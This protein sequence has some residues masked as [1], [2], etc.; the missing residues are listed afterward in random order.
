[1]ESTQES[2]VVYKDNKV[3]TRIPLQAPTMTVGRKAGMNVQLED[4]LISRWHATLFADGGRWF[5]VDKKSGNGTFLNGQRLVADQPVLLQNG[6]VADVGDL[7][8]QF[9][10]NATTPA[11]TKAI[12]TVTPAEVIE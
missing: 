10:L 8:L 9:Q 1:M 2:L 6:F 12:E 11:P 7:K 4:P 3:V 5:L